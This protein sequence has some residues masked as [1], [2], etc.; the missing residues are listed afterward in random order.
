VPYAPRATFANPYGPQV[1]FRTEDILPPGAVYIGPDDALTLDARAPTVSAPLHLTL[2]RLMPQ[3]VISSDQYDY[4]ISTTGTNV[5]EQIIYPSEGYLLSAHAFSE[6]PERGQLFIKLHARRNALGSDH[7]FGHLLMQGYIS[8]DD[9]LG[10]PQSQPES[11]L[12]GRGWLRV[13]TYPNPPAG[14]NFGFVVPQGVRWLLRAVYGQLVLSGAGTARS[15]SLI[16]GNPAGA[17]ALA[18]PVQGSFGP[19]GGADFTFAPGVAPT[20]SS[21]SIATPIPPDF[22]FSAGWNVSLVE[23][24]IQP[25]D[26]WS[27]I[28]VY[29]EEYVAT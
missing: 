19:G 2:R 13:I 16:I 21:G 11:S 28:S 10:F 9:H 12:S 18:I 17:V 15:V 25:L 29:V 22:L 26:Q 8:V 6:A 20:S 1:T 14:S 7:A 27:L 4:V 24:V 5:Q 3:G 23:S